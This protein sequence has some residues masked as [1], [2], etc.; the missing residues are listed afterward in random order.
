MTPR[1]IKRKICRGMSVSVGGHLVDGVDFTPDGICLE[2]MPTPL[3]TYQTGQRVPFQIYIESDGQP[4][5]VDGEVRWTDPHDVTP[6]IIPGVLRMGLSLQGLPANVRQRL[7]DHYKALEELSATEQA[8]YSALREELNQHISQAH[9]IS[10]GTV[11][12]ALAFFGGCLAMDYKIAGGH[13]APL[14]YVLPLGFLLLGHHLFNSCCLR[15]RRIASYLSY[16]YEAESE[17]LNWERALYDL[18]KIGRNPR[19][20]E[21]DIFRVAKSVGWACFAFGFWKGVCGAFLP[22]DQTGLG[23]TCLPMGPSLPLL[24][25]AGAMWFSYFLPKMGRLNALFTGA[26]LFEEE[27]YCYWHQL[28]KHGWVRSKDLSHLHNCFDMLF[29]RRRRPILEDLRIFSQDACAR[30]DRC[31][32][33]QRLQVIAAALTQLASTPFV[34]PVQDLLMAA[35]GVCDMLVLFWEW[36]FVPIGYVQPLRILL[37]L[38]A[39]AFMGGGWAETNRG[40]FYFWLGALMAWIAT[41]LS[42]VGWLLRTY[43]AYQMPG[44]QTTSLC[45]ALILVPGIVFKVQIQR[46]QF[47]FRSGGRKLQV[48]MRALSDFYRRHFRGNGLIDSFPS[49]HHTREEWVPLLSWMIF[50]YYRNEWEAVRLMPRAKVPMNHEIKQAMLP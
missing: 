10:T 28:Y 19:Y 8:E 39:V 7:A 13:L 42:G 1:A 6:S 50:L 25:L 41:V 40:R 49:E 29:C 36:G 21:M 30:A 5:L 46:K 4:G 38:F 16:H 35:F 20:S 34:Y 23:G 47:I 22:P 33:K 18:R 37:G 2:M 11:T 3:P 9:Q 32:L 12:L 43:P 48:P 31:D 44:W 24:I 45:A 26:S 17:S 27:Q 15:I 14:L